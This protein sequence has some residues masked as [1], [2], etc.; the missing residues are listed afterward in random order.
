MAGPWH[1]YFAYNCVPFCRPRWAIDYVTVRELRAE[2]GE[3]WRRVEAGEEIVITRSGKPFALLLHTAPADVEST[4]RAYRAAKLGT[5]LD[6]I[7]THSLAQGLDQ[8]SD[9]AVTA[10]IGAVRAERRAPAN[11]K[12]GRR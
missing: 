10:E 12:P 7:Q 4:L 6:R 2:S 1:F 11:A 5:V 3:V 9:E 8:I